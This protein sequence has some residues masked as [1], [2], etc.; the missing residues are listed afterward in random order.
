MGYTRCRDGTCI[1]T[2]QICDGT[3]HCH[4]NS[5]ED[6]RFCR[7]PI[8]LP[9]RPGIIITPPII[10]ILA[11]RPFEFTCVNSDG[12]RVDAVF[13]KDGSPVDGDPRFRVNRFNGSAL[14]VSASEG[15]RDIDDLRI[16][17]VSATGQREEITITISDECGLGFSKCKDGRCIKT[18]QFCDG[19]SNCQD[20][21]DED[22]RFCEVPSSRPPGPGL[23][24]YPSRIAVPAWRPFE[25]TC[26]SP[27]GGRISAV[28][29]T[30]G[31]SVGADRRFQ[32]IRYNTSAIQLRAPY[33]LLDIH[34]M[35]IVCISD[36]GPRQDINITIPDECGLG[37]TK[38]KDGSCIQVSQLCDATPQCR[39]G[40]DEDLLFCEVSTR[41]PTPSL[42]V[43][44]PIIN[45]PAW[46]PFECTCYS[47]EGIRIDA[48]FRDS[49]S[50]VE[51]DPRFRVTR[52]NDSY[53][54]IDAPDGLPDNADTQIECIDTGGRRDTVSV[55]VPDDCGRGHSKCKDGQCIFAS[56]WCDGTSH[57]R[58]KSDEDPRYCGVPTRP[59]P[60]P[61]IVFPSAIDVPAWQTF[62]FTC[63]SPEGIR[64]DAVFKADGSLV[65]KDP[66][67]QVIRYNVS[68]I[69]VTAPE[70]LPDL[71]DMQIACVDEME[72]ALDVSV[73]IPDEC[74]R[75]YVKCRDGQCIP[76]S[77]WCDRIPHCRDRSDE[78]YRF[79]RVLEPERPP[80]GPLIV[81]PP[82][83]NVSA[84]ERFEFICYSS[85]GSRI[86]AIFKND[87]SPVDAD[88]RFQVTRYNT[89]TL[90]IG[91]L[92]GLP[93]T[94][95]VE[96]ECITESGRRTEVP[97]TILKECGRGYTKCRDGQ[98][99]RES[100]WCDGTPHCT[101]GSDEDAVF[102]IGKFV[103]EI[104]IYFNWL[105]SY[106][107]QATSR[108]ICSIRQNENQISGQ[109]SE[110]LREIDMII[111]IN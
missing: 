25:F 109:F 4:D 71:G 39:D 65:E 56:Q 99:I 49:G 83:I 50:S 60:S 46:Q 69:Q 6:S 54:K 91:A 8:R 103:L 67:F 24:V 5:D 23:I 13:K 63:F 80:T 53:I 42:V 94:T 7:E 14:Y 93:D 62:N 77:Q 30:N 19:T 32:I 96:I 26:I 10:S 76:E 27:D 11:W 3:S 41:P 58:D 47:L 31:S 36:I 73:T 95:D 61:I 110:Q 74:G 102:C 52:Y 108:L 97:V 70:G 18:S 33:G 72:R 85:D 92:G 79:C 59:P 9:S 105:I 40:S 104:V 2:H 12:S 55:N 44:P 90:Q 21:S 98:C 107:R 48:M 51:A 1:P 87:G 89:S 38:C 84:W 22:P 101:D 43:Y 100:Q 16:E 15:L 37:Y 106:I 82:I 81:I 28:F 68:Y 86:S 34:D 111:S 57:C 88:S 35:Q 17:C 45:V 66:R 64:L 29:K 78:D 75:G 20:G